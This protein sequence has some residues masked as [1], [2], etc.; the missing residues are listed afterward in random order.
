MGSKL[1][2]QK[3]VDGH[4]SKYL[5]E[6]GH[7]KMTLVGSSV[8]KCLT[9]DAGILTFMNM[10]NTTSESKKRLFFFLAFMFL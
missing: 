5:Y 3:C 6:Q 10:I 4:F 2:P 9:R 8:V 1:D 7:G